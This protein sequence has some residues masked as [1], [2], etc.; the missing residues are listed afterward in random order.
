MRVAALLCVAGASRRERRALLEERLRLSY[1][2]FLF[3]AGDF[4]EGLSQLELCRYD[5]V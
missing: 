3:A 4:D 5:V 2:H 1:G